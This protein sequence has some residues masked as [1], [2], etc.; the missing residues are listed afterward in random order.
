M[1]NT[2]PYLFSNLL[3]KPSNTSLF[4]TK[5]AGYDHLKF[6]CSCFYLDSTP[7][8]HDL[9]SRRCRPGQ[10]ALGAPV[11]AVTAR[12]A[13]LSAC[14]GDGTLRGRRVPPPSSVLS[15]S[16]GFNSSPCIAGTPLPLL[17]RPQRATAIAAA[18][19][20]SRD[21]PELSPPLALSS[22]AVASQLLPVRSAAPRRPAS[23]QPPPEPSPLCA[24]TWLRS[25]PRSCI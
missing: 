17:I 15:M 21:P 7:P 20:S 22:S 2:S 11:H 3:Q 10:N 14:S 13:C 8:L 23:C 6:P 16:S 1:P 18:V 9:T 25:P 24:S 5:P 12:L 4:Q 19:C